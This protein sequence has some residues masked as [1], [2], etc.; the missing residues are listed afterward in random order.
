MYVGN[1]KKGHKSPV[2]HKGEKGGRYYISRKQKPKAERVYVGK[3][4]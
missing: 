4:K 2:L 3:R 1:N